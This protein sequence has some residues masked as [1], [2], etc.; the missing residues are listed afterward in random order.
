MVVRVSGWV[1]GAELSDYGVESI[2]Q[3]Y[4]NAVYRDLSG[5]GDL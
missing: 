3:A 5:R 4:L 2:E 1:P